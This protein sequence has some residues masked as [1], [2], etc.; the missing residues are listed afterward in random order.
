MTTKQY[1]HL[2]VNYRTLRK[3]A[4][5]LYDSLGMRTFFNKFLKRGKRATVSRRIFAALV[6]M[7]MSSVEVSSY[8]MV[9]SHLYFISH[10]IKLILVRKGAQLQEVPVP[11]K[12]LAAMTEALQSFAIA[13][14]ARLKNALNI[15]TALVEESY[16]VLMNGMSSAAGRR[17]SDLLYQ[18]YEK[19]TNIDLR[20]K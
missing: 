1:Q 17:L 2:T 4:D 14:R 16:D 5:P 7:R 20:F 3:R 6:E 8:N 10:P 15:K 11:V 19:R 13:V 12:R 9:H 18:I